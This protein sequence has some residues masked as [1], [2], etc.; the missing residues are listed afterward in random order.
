MSVRAL[1]RMVGGLILA[2]EI[3][4]L[5]WQWRQ[6]EVIGRAAAAA[7]AENRARVV[8]GRRVAD[9][10]ASLRQ[11]AARVPK[12][13]AVPSRPTPGSFADRFGRALKD[14]LFLKKLSQVQDQ[15][16]ADH[17]GPL[18]ER[19][20]LAPAQR[21]RFI[22]LL[23]EKQLAK[24]DAEAEANP[25]IGT[26]LMVPA[27]AAAQQ[28]VNGQIQQELGPA[29]YQSYYDFEMTDGLRTTVRRLQDSL[30]YSTAPL[31]DA[32]A[33]SL[34][35]TL[36]RITPAADRGGIAKFTGSSVEVATGLASQQFSAPLPAGAPEAAQA[37]L[38]EPQLA[39]LRQLMRQQDDELQLR[40]RTLAALHAAQSA[41]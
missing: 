9:L 33:E 29:A 7:Q 41:P 15:V 26:G 28:E 31:S 22:A 30:R 36:D 4:L 3:G 25:M 8:L 13:A 23:A 16:I 6:R 35:A 39:Q 32:Q 1:L 11:A 18:F 14:P 21:D 24:T 19:L 37:V 27:I 38:S 40:S 10:E 20:Q 2:A 34:V 12:P 17:Y 5:A